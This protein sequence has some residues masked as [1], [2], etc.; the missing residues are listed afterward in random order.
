[1]KGFSA[2][3]S[4]RTKM[5]T[6]NRRAFMLGGVALAGM[7]VLSA[8]LFQLQIADQEQYRLLSEGNQFNNLPIAPRRGRITDR[9]GRVIADNRRVWIVAMRKDRAS[10]ARIQRLLL[11]IDPGDDAPALRRRARRLAR[12]QSRL[13]RARRFEEVV[14]EDDL[15]WDEFARINLHLP[16]L[17]GVYAE[18]NEIR[19]YGLP[20][21]ETDNRRLHPDAFAHIL[22]Y[23]AKPSEEDIAERL[24]P[25]REEAERLSALRILRHPSFRTG[26]SGV[27]ASLEE[28]L[29]G[30]WGELRVEVDAHGRQIREAGI[31]RQALPGDDVALTIDAELQA[32]AQ[33]RLDGES[34]GCVALD[35]H[36]GEIIVMVSAPAFDA[37]PFT[38]GIRTEAYRALSHDPRIPLFNKPLD[39]LYPPGSTF[40]MITALAALRAGLAPSYRVHCSARYRVGNR[41]FSCWKK[42]GHGSKDLRGAMKAS[43]DVYFYDIARR[44]GI[45]ALADEAR[46]FGLG[47]RYDL[48][49]PGGLA[50]IVPDPAW[51][52]ANRGEPWV[53][54]ETLNIGIGQG[55]LN[56]S[57]LQ[58]AVMTARIANGGRPI[59][60]SIIRQQQPISTPQTG[61]ADPAHLQRVMDAVMGVTE[62][63]GGTAYW[64][65]EAKGIDI[66]GMRMAGKT[67]TS[68]VRYISQEERRRGVIKNEDLPWRRR[69]HALFVCAAPYD[70]PRYALALVVEHGGSGSK[71]AAPAARDILRE[72]LLRSPVRTASFEQGAVLQ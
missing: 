2:F 31:D 53:E 70:A 43:C 72:I 65:L 7:A 48:P 9:E 17:P 69:D 29:H 67:G 64:A 66:E 35:V 68:Q 39:G 36:T 37:N 42:E 14:L 28:Q 27:E 41:T 22:G 61:L 47:V 24:G 23:V 60:P 10:E 45:Q 62:E 49:L 58:L 4:D 44:V 16:Y 57:P 33:R 5:E 19:A 40:K 32:F 20:H 56:A 63:P 51:K 8:R 1:M 13:G 12:W 59:V 46:L 30:K 54:G 15:S 55:F 50:G 71:A 38:R 18:A 26:R 21:P 25:L 34:A 11:A 3:N 6:M 52:I